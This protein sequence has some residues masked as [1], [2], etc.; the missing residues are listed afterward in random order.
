MSAGELLAWMLL[1][2]HQDYRDAHP[3]TPSARDA[4]L[5][6][7]R[8]MRPS[9]CLDASTMPLCPT[10]EATYRETKTATHTTRAGVGVVGRLRKNR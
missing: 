1:V 6:L 10:E 3:I 5:R 4:F 8:Q 9:V 2:A 7:L